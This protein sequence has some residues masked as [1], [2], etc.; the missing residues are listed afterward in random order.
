MSLKFVIST[1]MT[2]GFIC[3]SSIF[4]HAEEPA[5]EPAE[6]V[7]AAPIRA[8]I[9]ENVRSWL[10]DPLLID[11]INQQNKKTALLVAADIMSLDK[12]WRFE[13]KN[14]AQPL[15][16]EVLASDLSK[17]LAKKQNDSDGML[18]E[19][20]VMDAKG[21]NVG[22]SKRTSDYWQG[23]EAKWQNTFLEGPDAIFIGD[24]DIDESTLTFQS[25]ASLSISDPETGK[26]IGAITLG[27]NF[28]K[29]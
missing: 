14:D 16:D 11:S 27:F 4:A 19:I 7:Y 18:L 3:F 10:S 5:E 17:F 20:F 15:I 22:Q 6:E 13:L 9:D 2:A 24:I 12:Q 25:Q 1:A 28:E 8:Y 29:L 23:D 21:L 26:V